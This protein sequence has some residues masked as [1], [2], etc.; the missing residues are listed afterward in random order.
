M[1]RTPEWELFQALFKVQL[2]HMDQGA[3][4]HQVRKPTTLAA[5]LPALQQLD[6]LR[7]APTPASATKRQDMSLQER[8]ALSKSWAAWAPGLKEAISTALRVWLHND[9]R[10]SLVPGRNGLGSQCSIRVRP[11]GP[12]ALEQWKQHY[13]H[14]H[15]PARRDCQHCVRASARSKPHRRVEHA[16]AFTL[17][18]D[19]T[20][21]MTPGKD[22]EGDE[23]SYFLVAVYTFP[24]TKQG[25]PLVPLPGHEEP[26]HQPLPAPGELLGEEEMP[27]GIPGEDEEANTVSVD[28]AD[29]APFGQCGQAD[30]DEIPV[31]NAGAEEEDI[32]QEVM[33]H[34]EDPTGGDAIRVDFMQSAATTWERLIQEN[35]NVTVTN[36]TFAEPVKSRATQ[37]VIP[38]IAK[39]YA[40]LRQMNL[41]VMRIHTDRA[42]EFR[43]AQ[44]RRWTLDRSIIHTM[45]AADD[46]KANGRVENEVQQIKKLTKVLIS[47]N[48]CTL[49][50]WPL[51]VRHASERRLRCQ[52]RAVGWPVGDLL[53]FGS[54]AFSVRK[55]WQNR[56]EAW[57]DN[58]EA[59]TVLGPA[60]FSS[61]TSTTYYVLSK[62]S[63]QWFYTSDV[64]IPDAQQPMEEQRVIYLPEQAPDELRHLPLD[65]PTHR[66]RGKQAPQANRLWASD[67]HLAQPEDDLSQGVESSW[68]LETRSSDLSDRDGSSGEDVEACGGDWEEVP[69]TWAGGSY[70]GTSIQKMTVLD[71]L[72]RNVTGYLQEEM[73]KLDAT[74]EVQAGWLP[75]LTAAFQ[76]KT[77]LEAQLKH[78][79][80]VQVAEQNQIIEEQF[81]VTRT[82]G[83][84]EVYDN[85]EDWKEAITNEYRQ[86][87]E[88]KKAAEPVSQAELQRRAEQGGLDLEILPA[89]MVFT[90]K[91]GSGAY[92]ARA[93]VCGNYSSDKNHDDVYA[94]GIDATQIRCLLQAS[95]A[96]GWTCASTDIRVAF[97]NAPRRRDNKLVAMQVPGV[98]KRLGLC[99]PGAEFWIIHLAMYGLPTSPKDWGVHRDRR[100]PQLRWRR[101]VGDQWRVG[102]FEPTGDPHLWRAVERGEDDA[103]DVLGQWV[104]LL[105][106]YVDDI[107]F[108]GIPEAVHSAL[109]AI[110]SEWATSG[111]EWCSAQKPIKFLGFEIRLDEGGNGLRVGQESYIQ[112][113]LNAWN[114]KDG[115][116]FPQ[117]K[118]GDTDFEAEEGA[119]PE[120]VKIAQAMCGALL[121]IATRT[122]PDLSYG[123]SSM[124]RIMAKRPSRAVAIGRALLRYLW[125]HREGLHFPKESE[126]PWGPTNQ[127]KRRR[128]AKTIEVFADI[129]YGVGSGGKSVQG[130]VVCVGG[131]PVSWQSN[132]QP[133]VC[134]STSE[135]ELTSY[136]E[137]LNVGRATEALV[138]AIYQIQPESEELDRIIYG[139]NL[140]SI[141]IARGEAAATWR[142]RH[143]K[144]RSNLL[145]EAL[146]PESR[147][148]GGRWSLLHLRGCDLMA[149]GLTKALQGQAFA[150]FLVNMGLCAKDEVKP[151]KGAGDPSVNRLALQ[152]VLVGGTLGTCADA[153]K[154]E[155]GEEGEAWNYVWAGAAVLMAI[156]AVQVGKSVVNGVGTCLRRLRADDSV[157]VVSD[158]EVSGDDL[159]VRDGTRTTSLSRETHSGSAMREG[160]RTTS[161]PRATHSGSA[162]RDGTC[163][164][165][166][167]RAPHSGS[168]MRDGTR[169]TSQPMTTQSGSA[170]RDGTRTASS[171][172][173]PQ[174]GSAMRDGTHNASLPRASQSGS[175]VWG[176][177]S[178]TSRPS[179]KQSGVA[180]CCEEGTTSMSRERCSGLEAR[181]EECSA[182]A[183]GVRPRSKKI[184]EPSAGGQDGE[185]SSTSSRMQDNTGS[186][187]DAKQLDSVVSQR[188]GSSGNALMGTSAAATSSMQGPAV[189]YGST[190][191]MSVWN[192]FQH[193]N[194]GKGW[195]ST[196][197]SQEYHE[198]KRRGIL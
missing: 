59:V 50:Q 98:F 48:K 92:R 41:P 67:T 69:N 165:S 178:T 86:L 44:L 88:V 32:L 191:Y 137:A 45:T 101:C 163:T 154:E 185:D 126:H 162:M 8:C 177:P 47:S 147:A 53:P 34:D 26:T 37:H 63:G 136:C 93:V 76:E 14:D 152:A 140:S 29:E 118:V 61:L 104:G 70:P 193:S 143:L 176:D 72:H 155:D 145:R 135:S 117:F 141:S 183:G 192:H 82:I 51:A 94:G 129:S 111:L 121:W 131:A 54:T 30:S 2:F 134:Q 4:G 105:G 124:S 42:K 64:I 18:I 17:G 168:A 182:G 196:R 130:L 10:S 23:V 83:N 173:T 97:L 73:A 110:E 56:Y 19:L 39:V 113:V 122:R 169:T 180:E 60:K 66:V 179:R 75:A 55:W 25:Q 144:L 12:I 102:C 77:S 38:A 151:R 28:A 35:K 133:Y 125:C 119:S 46:W 138:A 62:S 95:A 85:L 79:H 142:T 107:L 109:G 181:N 43:S 184:K 99:Q 22:Q 24:T 139:D 166:R 189:Q 150:H 194:R 146:D 33:E 52:L 90:R 116:S 153:G 31:D 84:Q 16:E 103:L 81:L 15:Y 40:R 78:L 164:T 74:D 161:R 1:W 170:M 21:R 112:E 123:V 120:D 3:M 132:Q 159:V 89:K 91:A 114:I 20:G 167:P 96:Q 11:L 175:A 100:L 188:S 58:R 157:V 7:G 115:T 172:M 65:V 49:E 6:G 36:L 171:P 71:Q 198:L 57:R 156:G 9:D 5:V 148:P 87:V 187:S 149:D 158:D 13:L 174:S 106:V 80:D 197:M 190:R 68:T 160:T 127:L 186:L 27:V 128:H 195:D 108:T